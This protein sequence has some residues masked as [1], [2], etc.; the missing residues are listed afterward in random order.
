MQ[1]LT[2]PA[3]RMFPQNIAEAQKDRRNAENACDA[4]VVRA[5]NK[6]GAL[7]SRLDEGRASGS[8]LHH[9][10]GVNW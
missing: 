9:F 2:E 10:T 3:E 1:V 8:S 4:G 6:K 5:S 7:P